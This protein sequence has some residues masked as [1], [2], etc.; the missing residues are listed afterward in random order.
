[1]KNKSFNYDPEVLK[2]CAELKKP[3]SEKFFRSLKKGQQNKL[4]EAVHKLHH[5]IFSKI[6]CLQCANCCKN[7]GPRISD[8]DIEKLSRH[9]RIK[10]SN[11]ISKYLRI[12][13]DR[14][15]VFKKMP[16][17]FLDS[18]NYC[19]V[20]SER[21]KACREYPH[22]DRRRIYQIYDLIIK[23]TFIC[24]AVYEIMEK[25]KSNPQ[26]IFK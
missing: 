2:K 13:E 12:D 9:F 11:F 1:M 18:E 14:D 19:L 21:P 22:T 15:Y 24:P 3:A 7:L 6:D 17:P 25:L 26:Y 16:C 8:R 5:V 20:Y 4:D 10:P 23:N